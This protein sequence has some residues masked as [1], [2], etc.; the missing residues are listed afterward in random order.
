MSMPDL[1]F[2]WLRYTIGNIL[3]A[4]MSHYNSYFKEITSQYDRKHSK[5]SKTVSSPSPIRKTKAKQS[6]SNVARYY[7]DKEYIR[8]IRDALR[9]NMSADVI[10]NVLLGYCTGAA[11]L[12]HGMAMMMLRKLKIAEYGL[13]EINEPERRGK[14]LGETPRMRIRTEIWRMSQYENSDG[15]M[16]LLCKYNRMYDEKIN[17]I[18][19][20]YSLSLVILDDYRT[21]L[22]REVCPEHHLS[23]GM[24]PE[25]AR[26]ARNIEYMRVN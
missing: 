25:L 23:L 18:M 22:K 7:T 15:A 21:L 8:T 16:P 9:S 11:E 12:A 24:C 3:D 2:C 4:K 13:P 17:S 5:Q 6:N 14:W 19:N 10:N 1:F 20:P 26:N